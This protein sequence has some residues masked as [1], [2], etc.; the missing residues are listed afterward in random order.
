VHSANAPSV[1]A[2]PFSYVPCL[3]PIPLPMAKSNDRQTMIPRSDMQLMKSIRIQTLLPLQ[4][5]PRPTIFF[6]EIESTGGRTGAA[7]QYLI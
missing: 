5:K 1:L 4:R 7:A 3:L 2:A 6:Y